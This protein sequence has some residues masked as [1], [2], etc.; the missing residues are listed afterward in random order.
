MLPLYQ[1]AILLF[2]YPDVLVASDG[3]VEAKRRKF[4]KKGIIRVVSLVLFLGSINIIAESHSMAAAVLRPTI[5]DFYQEPAPFASIITLHGLNLDSGRFLRFKTPLHNCVARF[6]QTPVGDSSTAT[7]S[8]PSVEEMSLAL[9][10]LD[11]N[12]PSDN[13]QQYALAGQNWLFTIEGSDGQ[14]NAPTNITLLKVET[15]FEI[16]PDLTT[17]NYG[18]VFTVSTPYV[19]S[20]YNQNPEQLFDGVAID[21]EESSLTKHYVVGFMDLIFDF[22]SENNSQ[23]VVINGLGMATAGDMPKRDPIRWLL[24][25]TNS[26]SI[27]GPTDWV[28]IYE[29]KGL[30]DLL[31]PDLDT[32]DSFLRD[33]E[34]G[35]KTF[36][37]NTQFYKY[38]RFHVLENFGTL[39]RTGPEETQLSS[40]RL[41]GFGSGPASL[42]SQDTSAAVTSIPYPDPLQDSSIESVTAQMDIWGMSE[43]ITVKGDFLSVITN[44]SINDKTLP[45]TDWKYSPTEILISYPVTASSVLR[46]QIWNGRSP[47]LMEK[48]VAIIEA[49]KQEQVI[50]PIEVPKVEVKEPALVDTTFKKVTKTIFCYKGKTLKKVRAVKPVC[51]KGYRTK[52]RQPSA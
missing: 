45:V 18:T 30:N 41:F 46:V 33:S 42:I 20:I 26:E 4:M 17:G 8:L 1:S 50:E 13:C 10:S 40:L 43:T 28:D 52:T 16:Y 24:Q 38:I 14:F 35:K 47:L 9:S 15:P 12:D 36:R 7:V 3:L 5:N 2:N 23:G 51:P 32:D 25:G 34:Y 29:A 37:E 48:T 6:L 27:S 21:P 31:P 22:R 11:I 44:V 19:P 49:P 39:S